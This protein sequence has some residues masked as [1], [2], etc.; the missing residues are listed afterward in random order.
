MGMCGKLEWKTCDDTLILEQ[1]GDVLPALGCGDHETVGDA[2][3]YLSN[4]DIQM[5]SPR[6][7]ELNM[8]T[9]PVV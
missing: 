2:L 5:T 1:N 6:K 3:W 9:K 8:V 4:T 7:K